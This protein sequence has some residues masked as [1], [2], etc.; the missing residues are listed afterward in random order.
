MS[1]DAVSEDQDQPQGPK[2]AVITGG[3]RGIGAAIGRRLSKDGYAIALLDLNVQGAQDTAA[4]IVAAGGIAYGYGC[5]VSNTEQVTAV[6]ER[7]E[8]DLGGI[9]AL[10]NNAGVTRDNLIF[11]MTDEDWD[12]IMNVHLRGAFVCTRVAQSHMVKR[13]SGRIV[14]MSS[15]NA[16]GAR[17][18]LNYSTA[19]MGLQGFVKTCAIELG[20]FN[21]TANAVAPGFIETA[22]TIEL[23]DRLGADYEQ[24]KAEAAAQV[25]LQRVGTPQD[26]ANVVSFLCGPDASY[27]SGQ[28]IYVCGGPR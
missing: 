28:V 1:D 4:E 26:I 19:K 11:K 18:Q 10:I 6:M 3:A 20:R 8:D 2:V 25:P 15:I 24:W 14:C 13:G 17:G 7:I 22:M 16:D 21:I 9:D 23:A 12:L 5:D 27:V